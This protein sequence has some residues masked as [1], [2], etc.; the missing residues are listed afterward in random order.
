MENQGTRGGSTARS[1]PVGT[2]AGAGTSADATAVGE[3]I[4]AMPGIS[5]FG[6]ASDTLDRMTGTS[7]NPAT[8]SGSTS[9]NSGATAKVDAGIGKAAGGM[10]KIVGAI[11]DKSDDMGQQSGAAGTVGSVAAAAADRLEGASQYL[12]GADSQRLMDDLESLVR[13][14]PVESMLAAAGIGFVLA[15]VLR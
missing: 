8:S 9:G 5:D 14:K 2:Y 6:A 10:D 11:R 12:H 1:K 13:R 4:D 15:K 3:P 7:P